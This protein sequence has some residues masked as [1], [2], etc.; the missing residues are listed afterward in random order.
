[1]GSS[2]AFLEMKPS[3]LFHLRE[4]IYHSSIFLIKYYI[5]DLFVEFFSIIYKELSIG[6]FNSNSRLKVFEGFTF[7]SDKKQYSGLKAEAA[8]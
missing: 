7:I 8:S 5:E 4:N 1:M 3:I 6:T 2:R